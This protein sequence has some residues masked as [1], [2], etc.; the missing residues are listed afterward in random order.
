[1]AERGW[2]RVRDVQH[3]VQGENDGGG[4]LDSIE[5]RVRRLEGDVRGLHD[6]IHGGTDGPGL[7]EL[8]RNQARDILAL[9]E[10]TKRL[11]ATTKALNE[12]RKTELDIR[13]GERRMMRTF[14]NIAYALLILG[15]AGGTWFGSRIMTILK[16]L[17]R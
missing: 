15:G 8:V 2:G 5:Q 9:T 13:E 11:E 6:Y 17:A 3:F 10:S 4:T 7:A 1:M 14:R 16:E 12:V